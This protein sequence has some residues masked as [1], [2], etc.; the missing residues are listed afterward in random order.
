MY[1]FGIWSRNTELTPKKHSKE[2]LANS[3]APVLMGKFLLKMSY[4]ITK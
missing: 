1:Y 3:H 2:I 4:Y